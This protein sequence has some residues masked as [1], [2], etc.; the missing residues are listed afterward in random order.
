MGYNPWGCK[1]ADTAEHVCTVK[2]SRRER[3]EER[4]E[5]EKIEAGENTDHGGSV[6]P[7]HKK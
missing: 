2:Q 1:E 5:R 4:E 7:A 6:F 3:K